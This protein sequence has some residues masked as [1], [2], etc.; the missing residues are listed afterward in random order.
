MSN[1]IDSVTNGITSAARQS[2][3][4]SQA[5][6][7][8]AQILQSSKAASAQLS[9]ADVGQIVAVANQYLESQPTAVRFK[10]DQSDGELITSIY[11]SETNE[12]IREIPSQELRDI[13]A[14]LRDYRNATDQAGLLVDQLV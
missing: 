7:K 5:R 14:K 10:V 1:N 8:Q 9:Q 3:V 6:A 13:S 4:D 11:N 2:G 12:L